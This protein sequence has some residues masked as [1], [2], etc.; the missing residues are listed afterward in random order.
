MSIS[1]STPWPI[2]RKLDEEFHFDLD[3][4][5]TKANAKCSRYFTRNQDGLMQ[6]WTGTVFMNP[7]YGRTIGAWT[8]RAWVCGTKVVGLLPVRSNAPWWHQHVMKAAEIRF[9]RKKLSFVGNGK[10]V[11]FWASAIVIWLPQYEGVP[12]VSS[13]SQP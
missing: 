7:P 13:W 1:Y 5:A 9:V 2:F 6:E 11:P 12:V 10:G 4:C 3:V 8:H